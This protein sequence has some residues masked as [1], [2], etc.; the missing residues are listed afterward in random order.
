MTKR[1]AALQAARDYPM[2]C[3]S[4]NP[5]TCAEEDKTYWRLDVVAPRFISAQSH[6]LKSVTD[7]HRI[8]RCERLR[9]T[10]GGNLQGRCV[11]NAVSARPFKGPE[12]I[13]LRRRWSSES[14]SHRQHSPANQVDQQ[15]MAMMLPQST[16]PRSLFGEVTKVMTCEL[17]MVFR[18]TKWH[19]LQPHMF[20]KR[21]VVLATRRF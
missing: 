3:S 18:I 16:L 2:Y 6:Y 14:E 1:E 7:D 13:I 5:T 10:N 21:W 17:R 15:I 20:L 12:R 9:S 4:C 8:P 11:S 19:Q